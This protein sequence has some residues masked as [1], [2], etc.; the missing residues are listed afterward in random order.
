[1]EPLDRAIAD[2]E[3]LRRALGDAVAASRAQRDLIR[4]LDVDN[5]ATSAA[6]RAAF[7]EHLADL[8]G[9]LARDLRAAGDALGLDR[10]TL[11]G[12][13]ARAPQAAQ[14]L[15]RLFA[16]VRA[17]AAT[18]RE[19]DVCNHLLAARAQA[20]VRGAVEALAPPRAT[21]YDR[22]GS[23][24]LARAFSTSSRVA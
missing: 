24:T 22:R 15:G 3:E 4:R 2:T 19:L 18:L 8:Q 12:M 14:R 17:L 21:A 6:R 7:N 16:D 20:S 5:L 13:K 9:Q 10:V 23:A 1:M 11:D